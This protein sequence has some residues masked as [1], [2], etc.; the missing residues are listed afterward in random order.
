MEQAQPCNQKQR[1]MFARLVEGAKK[2]ESEN[3][4]S[5]FD[6][7]YRIEDEVVRKLAQEEE[8]V[9]DLIV[10]IGRLRKELDVA[11]KSLSDL[12]FYLKGDQPNLSSNAPAKLRETLEAEQRSARKERERSLKNYDLA[13]LGVWSAETTDEAKGIVEAL[14]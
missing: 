13:I 12:G 14:L 6:M 4:E 11:V 7:K 2:R 10:K 3:L 5:E 1:E 8:G 9:P